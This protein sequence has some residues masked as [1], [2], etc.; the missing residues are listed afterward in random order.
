MLDMSE[1][2]QLI[3]LVSGK[4]S[5]A[6]SL[7][8]SKQSAAGRAVLEYSV[9]CGDEGKQA[10][11]AQCIGFGGRQTGFPK[12]QRDFRT[13]TDTVRGMLNYRNFAILL[14]YTPVRGAEFFHNTSAIFLIKMKRKNRQENYTTKVRSFRT[15]QSTH[16]IS[17][18]WFLFQKS[19]Y[20]QAA[21]IGNLI[22]FFRS[23]KKSF[24]HYV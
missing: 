8:R 10:R 20:V 13:V 16:K 4:R 18:M 17:Y 22:N 19:R 3:G 6:R 2:P 1:I 24:L 9:M 11:A 7:K 21:R 12:V 5:L 15:R 23:R 14:Y